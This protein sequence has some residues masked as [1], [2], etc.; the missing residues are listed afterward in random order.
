MDGTVH[1]SGSNLTAKFSFLYANLWAN[2]MPVK[3]MVRK[4]VR[5]KPN[6]LDGRP[7]MVVLSQFGPAVHVLL[8]R[9][10]CDF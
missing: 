5:R 10:G 2:H 8:S 7:I 4:K 9:I 6:V 1:E 3:D